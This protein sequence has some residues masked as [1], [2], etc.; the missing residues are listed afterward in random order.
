MLS[1]VEKT[2]LGQAL[3][4]VGLSW[5][6][7]QT[8]AQQIVVFGSRALGAS[9]GA[10]DWD[11]LCV[12]AG[13]SRHVKGIDLVWVAPENLQSAAWLG[14]ELGNHVAT[15]GR[16][17]QGD[18]GWRRKA[19]VSG[20][21]VEQKSRLLRARVGPSENAGSRFPRPPG[22]STSCVF[23]GTFRGWW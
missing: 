13:R 4:K 16:W 7:V 19:S 6:E 20:A 12:G 11:L 2:A 23:G 8:R 3:G 5:E 10:S 17:L 18:D 14:S 22:G 15:Y 9:S 1:P 21:A